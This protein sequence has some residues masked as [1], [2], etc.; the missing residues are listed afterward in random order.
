MS[1]PAKFEILTFADDVLVVRAGKDV[2]TLERQM[3]NVLNDIRAV[4]QSASMFIK[5]PQGHNLHA[6]IE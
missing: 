3:Q 4:C 2:A 6:L 5:T 1:L